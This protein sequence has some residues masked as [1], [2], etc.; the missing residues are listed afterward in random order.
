MEII[1]DIF[2]HVPLPFVIAW[3]VI[4]VIAAILFFTGIRRHIRAWKQGRPEK[5]SGTPLARLRRLIY[6]GIAQAKVLNKKYNGTTHALISIVGFL[7]LVGMFF[8]IL[9]AVVGYLA[10]L[11]GAGLILLEY[12]R[13]RATGPPL[14]T[15]W[16]DS[17]VYGVI[18]AMA[19]SG[20]LMMGANTWAWPSPAGDVLS[21]LFEPLGPRALVDLYPSLFLIH[22]ALVFSLIAYIPNSRLIHLITSPLNAYYTPINVKGEMTTPFDLKQMMETGNFDVKV[23]ATEINDFTWRQKL[24]F[25]AC[26]L[27]VRCSDACPAKASGTKLSPMHLILKLKNLQLQ[28]TNTARGL[29]GETVDPEELWACTTCRACVQECP[30]L[31]QHVEAIY[32]MRRHLMAEGKVDKKKRDLITF[33][34]N[35]GNTYGLPTAD[36]MKWAEGLEIKLWGEDPGQEFLYWVGCAGSYDTR[37]QKVSRALVKIM[38]AARVSFGVLGNDEKCNCEVARR[39][40]EEGR[41]QQTAMELIEMMN[42]RGVKKIVTQ[43]PHCYN[44]FKNEYP[45]FGGKFEVVHHTQ[46]IAKLL[47]DGRLKL[48]N[49]TGQ[50]ITYHDPCYLGRYNDEYEAPRTIIRTLSSGKLLE[51]PRSRAKSFCC[52]GGGGNTWYT[53]ESQKKCSVIRIE[54]AQ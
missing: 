34:T 52:G 35:V 54:E 26:T 21:P 27:C 45:K 23:G 48:K 41:Y 18:V 24:S 53:V 31:I 30:V 13:I 1:R 11:F 4:G 49:G 51:L 37:N 29:H 20:F 16:E 9:E 10:L 5:I 46:L 40:G 36:R 2:Q 44:T 15:A 39:V 38:K 17:F 19:V 3:Y 22:S 12:K 28:S 32:D 47:R 42:K 8:P 33:L 43:C 25:D 50:T 14:E 7:L 6:V